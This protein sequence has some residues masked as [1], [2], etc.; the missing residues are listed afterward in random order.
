VRARPLGTRIPSTKKY[1]LSAALETCVQ[2]FLILIKTCSVH[3]LPHPN[4]LNF[5]QIPLLESQAPGAWELTASRGSEERCPGC[6]KGGFLQKSSQLW[7][8]PLICH[9]SLEV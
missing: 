2:C 6:L 9:E 1:V 8:E 7:P 3:P 4:Q 5:F